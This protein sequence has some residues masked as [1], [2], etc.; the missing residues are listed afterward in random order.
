MFSNGDLTDFVKFKGKQVH[1]PIHLLKFFRATFF[2]QDFHLTT[3]DT[4]FFLFADQ[5]DL[6]PKSNLFGAVMVN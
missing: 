5:Q 3:Y 4:V 6:Q 2:G 1:F